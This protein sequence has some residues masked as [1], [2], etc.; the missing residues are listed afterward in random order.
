MYRLGD[1]RLRTAL[2][3]RNLR[4]LADSKLNVTLAAQMASHILGCIRPLKHTPQVS[5]HGLKLPEFKKH[6]GIL[7]DTEFGFWVVLCAAR[8][9]TG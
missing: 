6:L 7:S 2:E 8:S 1:E 4:V 5:G 3:R 9:C